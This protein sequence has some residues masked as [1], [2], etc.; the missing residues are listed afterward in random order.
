[1][2]TNAMKPTRLSMPFGKELELAINPADHREQQRLKAL[3]AYRSAVPPGV[4]RGFSLTPLDK[5]GIPVW[6]VSYR[7]EDGY[8]NDGIGYGASQVESLCG[9]FGELIETA[10]NHAAMARLP[11]IER[12]S[13]QQLVTQKGSEHVIDPRT[14]CLEAGTLEPL[15]RPLDWLP[16]LTLREEREVWVPREFVANSSQQLR[17]KDSLITPITNGLGAGC[18]RAQAVSHAVME[19]LQRDGNA[20]AFRAMDRGIVIELDDIQDTGLKDLLALAE[21]LGIHVMPKLATTEFGFVNVYVVGRD[22]VEEPWFSLQMTA[23]GEAS[24]PTREA[25][26]RKALLEYFAARVRKAFMHG[27]LDHIVEKVTGSE[28]MN[29]YVQHLNLASEEP[30]ALDAMCD[31]LQ[32]TSTQLQNQLQGTVF[33]QQKTVPLSTLP[34]EP[35]A[36]DP[37]ARLAILQERLGKAGLDILFVDFADAKAKDQGVHAVRAIVPGLECETMSYGRMGYRGVQRALQ[38]G[39]DFVQVGEQP[40]TEAL[41]IAMTDAQT[42]LIG[43][44]AWLDRTRLDDIVGPLYPLYREPHSHAAQLA[45]MEKNQPSVSRIS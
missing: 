1:M 6:A 16:A 14:L 37:V 4:F 45:L 33:S 10:M 24:H 29:D 13:Y 28:Y 39:L 15:R 3:Q 9:A 35:A 8:M 41:A 5:T 43:G 25:A 32:K 30:R 36:D 7:S 23:C 22:I 18:S 44:P 21:R 38:E 11:S 2:S 40:N 20:T 34:T 19:L 27:P 42:Q 26:I 17:H 31:W 12:V